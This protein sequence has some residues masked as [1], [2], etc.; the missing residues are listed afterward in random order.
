MWRAMKVPKS[1]PATMAAGMP[2]MTPNRITHAWSHLRI[3]ATAAGPG[4]GGIIE[5]DTPSP[6]SSGTPK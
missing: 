3:S 5:W 6:A 2:A 4:V 1:G